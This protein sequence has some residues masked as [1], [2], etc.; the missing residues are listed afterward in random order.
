M[1]KFE[2]HQTMRKTIP[3]LI[4]LFLFVG[5]VAYG[6]DTLKQYSNQNVLVIRDTITNKISFVFDANGLTAEQ[7]NRMRVNFEIELLFMRIYK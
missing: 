6:Q 2:K 1:F 3:F 7:F 4:F 5:S